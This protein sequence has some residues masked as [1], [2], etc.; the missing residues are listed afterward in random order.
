MV[1]LDDQWGGNP[2]AAPRK[3]VPCRLRQHYRVLTMSTTKD[4]LDRI[5]SKI[6]NSLHAHWRLFLTEGILLMVLG[7]LAIVVPN[8]ATLAFAVFIGWLLLL[9]GVVGLI[10][11]L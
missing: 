5:Q 4:E 9:S 2:P 11:T 7:V 1:I 3:S 8:V 6:T 10:A